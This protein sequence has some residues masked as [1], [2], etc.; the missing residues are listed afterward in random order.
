MCF[1][2]LFLP[3]VLA[4]QGYSLEV[5]DGVNT[6]TVAIPK[7]AWF[8]NAPCF[9]VWVNLQLSTVDPAEIY[10]ERQST[11]RIR[12]WN[13]ASN[14]GNLV[15]TWTG[16][17]RML[18]DLGTFGGGGAETFWDIPGWSTT[19]P[20]R[21]YQQGTKNLD[22]HVSYGHD[23]SAY[24]IAGDYQRVV[25]LGVYLDRR[26]G[27]REYEI[28]REIWRGWWMQGRSVSFWLEEPGFADGSG[29]TVLKYALNWGDEIGRLDQ[30]TV[31]P[32]AGIWRPERL[33]Q[34]KENR[35]INDPDL[36]FLIKPNRNPVTD[37]YMD[38]LWIPS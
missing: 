36:D 6:D 5:T 29:D 1:R 33:I 16:T 17:G 22:G 4:D 25:Q 31:E 2:S 35:D 32:Q 3:D 10:L 9:F 15:Y 27:A 19:F 30:L 20:L 7:G 21:S 18:T 12:L 8:A 28:W 24:S 34:S 13:V 37:T 26:E 38:F 23:G 11:G 14:A